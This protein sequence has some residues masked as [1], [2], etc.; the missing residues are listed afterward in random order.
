MYGWIFMGGWLDS[1]TYF[2]M[3]ETYWCEQGLA[4]NGDGEK[5]YDM[6]CDEGFCYYD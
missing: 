6:D 5:S 4:A 3:E 1:C 2:S